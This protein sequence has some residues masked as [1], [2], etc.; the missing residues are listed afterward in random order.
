MEPL[1]A[2]ARIVD[3][4]VEVWAP[5]QSP[6]GARKEIAERLKMPIENVTVHV[7]LLGGGFGRKSKWDFMLEAVHISQK[8]GGAP[9]L[10][11]WSREDDIHHSLLS[12]DLGRAHRDGDRRARA[13]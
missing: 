7:T 10:L 6:Y 12:H 5:V 13:R 8:L 11:Q 1:V 3:G 4:K 9:V 2:V